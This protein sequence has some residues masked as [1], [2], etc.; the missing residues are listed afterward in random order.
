[1]TELEKAVARALR[2][3]DNAAMKLLDTI[4]RNIEVA[5]AELI[6]SGVSEDVVNSENVLVDQA[7]ITYCQMVMGDESQYDRQ[8]RAFKY[9]QDNLRKS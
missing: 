7:V 9:Q 2:L 6:R 8:F 3:S 4:Q 5:K 1:M